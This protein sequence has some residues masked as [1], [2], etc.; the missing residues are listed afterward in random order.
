ML[1]TLALLWVLFEMRSLVW[2]IVISIFLSLALEPGVR[3]LGQRYGWSR[4]A[5]VGVIYIAGIAFLVVM[6]LVLILRS[7]SWGSASAPKDPAGL[8]H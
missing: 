7:S 3:S 1:A 2:M 6:V 5:S 8:A 4:G